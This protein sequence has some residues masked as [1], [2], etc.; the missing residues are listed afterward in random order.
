MRRVTVILQQDYPKLGFIG[1]QIEVRGGYAR[2]Y[3]LPRGI[4]FESSEAHAR[5]IKHKLS[6]VT[7]KKIK[8]KAEAER[9]VK[10]MEGMI[11]EFSLRFGEGGKSFGSISNRD[12]AK[13]LDD[14]G[15]KLD[16]TQIVISEPIKKAGEHQVKVRLHADVTASLKVRVSVEAPVAAPSESAEKPAPRGR[17]RSRK[18]VTEN[19]ETTEDKS[20]S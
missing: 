8:L 2:N 9:I 19:S 7:A 20:A 5:V 3:L 16:R 14:K 4:A 13:W 17:G 11:P 10:E 6:A 1:D 12:L 15:Y 18:V